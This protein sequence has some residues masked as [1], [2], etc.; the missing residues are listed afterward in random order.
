MG[1]DFTG[2][3]TYYP[4]AHAIFAVR[5]EEFGSDDT[6]E[7][8]EIPGHMR[9]AA[10][11]PSLPVTEGPDG[12]FVLDAEA[13][14]PD[15]THFIKGVIPHSATLCLNGIRE[16]DTLSLEFKYADLP[17]DPRVVRA[18]G[19]SFYLGCFREEEFRAGLRGLPQKEGKRAGDALPLLV[20]PTDYVD[21]NGQQRTNL[22]FD[23]WVDEWSVEFGESEEPMVRMECTDNTRLL[24]EQIAPQS[25]QLSAAQPIDRAIANYLALFPQFKGLSVQ[26]R[27]TGSDVPSLDKIVNNTVK[28]K[29]NGTP[30]SKGS[31]LS[32]WD[33]LTDNVVSL[34]HIV[35][36]EGT[37]IIIQ[38]PR[39]LYGDF[40]VR[41][42]DP[43]TKASRQLP[44]GTPIKRRLYVYGSNISELDFKRVYPN[45]PANI[46]CRC[47]L[48]KLKK[49]L[50]KRWPED[51]KARQKN[52][53]PGKSADEKWSV[54]VVQ[55][56]EDE[57]T[58]LE[59]ARNIYETVGRN[60]LE[61]TFLTK[62]LGS[63]GGE[64][65]DPDA[66]DAL[67]GDPID[68]EIARP[69]IE[70]VPGTPP[71]MLNDPGFQ[72]EAFV[73][74]LGFE[75][76]FAKAYGAAKRS[77]L[78]TFRVKALTMDWNISEGVQLRFECINYIESRAEKDKSQDAAD[79]AEKQQ[80][81]AALAEPEE[82]LEAALEDLVRA[83][84]EGVEGEE[85][86]AV[87]LGEKSEEEQFQDLLEAILEPEGSE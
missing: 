59:T 50:V 2:K 28:V 74:Q 77:V 70:L 26:Y 49:T 85:L 22:R 32:V 10:N 62:D 40:E 71:E 1:Q 60:E 30:S 54:F 3:K 17:I 13:S 47:Y 39:T 43:F 63:F 12:S 83:Q 65:L 20:V 7:T 42:G 11:S 66:L 6:P 87:L 55:G 84:L 37:T 21:S 8:P 82:A 64:N 52:L 44:D 69:P 23:G 67:P 51:K 36:V 33:Y 5:F 9:N 29:K 53:R 18:C 75:E 45:A 38:R 73:T 78:N 24:I 16:A 25:E 19:V 31:K 41:T 57:A 34:G 58:L 15:N 35:R 46:E 80:I 4:G 86:E 14:L 48:P 76:K 72:A 79:D 68:V 61:M 56:I 27:P 81:E